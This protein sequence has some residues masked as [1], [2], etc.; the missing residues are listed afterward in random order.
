MPQPV[1]PPLAH[2]P[3]HWAVEHGILVCAKVAVKV[4]GT[5]AS[6]VVAYLEIKE[7]LK[8]FRRPRR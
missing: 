7:A 3:P 6:P 5:L 2:R 4:C 1:K 8:Y